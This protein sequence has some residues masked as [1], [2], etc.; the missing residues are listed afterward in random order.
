MKNA[1]PKTFYGRETELAELEELWT[2]PGAAL[3]VCRGRRRIGKSTL[4][5][6]FAAR[7]RC[8]FLKFEGKA[9]EPGQRNQDQ[10]DEFCRA[11][12]A[13]TDIPRTRVEDWGSAFALL[14]QA[15]A[16]ARKTVVLFDEISWMGK[17]APEFPGDLK[18][19]WDNLFRKHPRLIV[20]LCGSVSAWIAENILDN[21]GF[22]GRVSRDLVLRELPLRDC[23]KF[24]GAKAERISMR[25][26]VDVLSVTG[27]V[28]KYL[29]ELNPALS[30][31]ENIRRLCF[32]A[33][34]P[35]ARDFRQIFHD[36]F[37]SNAGAKREILRALAEGPKTPS[38]LAEAL[39]SER[40]GHLARNLEDLELAGFAA[41]DSGLNPSTG[42]RA[43]QGRCR[44]ADN[45]TRFFL[46]FIEPH[47]P[48]IEAGLF[49]FASL[50]S[51][52]GWETVLGLQFENLVLNHATELLPFLGLRGVPILSAAPFREKGSPSGKGLQVDL[53]IQTRKSVCVVEIKRQK[54]IGETVEEEVA[55]KVARLKVRKGLSVRTALVYEGSLAPVVS[56]NAWFD[57]IVPI[58]RLFGRTP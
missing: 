47:L 58:E 43:R 41:R 44:L 1:P 48:E 36:V 53:L 21:T 3:V 38:E 40:G 10:L 30:A 11:L 7:S 27:G 45:Y 29:E 35:L 25:E 23:L 19:A 5:E 33:S 46:R 26:V 9:P 22:V 2:K 37:G 13:Q 6:Q 55:R 31:D 4:V 51:L 49:D 56:G 42:I 52:P 32:R 12:A 57:A 54:K 50:E 15:L 17:H 8:R 20:V 14:D 16:S 24:W 34:G 28:P 39:G 18:I